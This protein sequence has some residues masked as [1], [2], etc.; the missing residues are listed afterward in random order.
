MQSTVT[1]TQF[2]LASNF[3]C[4]RNIYFFWFRSVN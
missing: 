3:Y 2:L 1:L 4:R